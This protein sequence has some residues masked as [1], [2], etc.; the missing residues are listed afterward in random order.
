VR[1]VIFT[2]TAFGNKFALLLIIGKA[3][4]PKHR[5]IHSS[6]VPQRASKPFFR[7]Y[8]L[9]VSNGKQQKQQRQEQ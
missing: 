4:E 7:F 1:G 5:P 8:G 6:K 2:Q 3:F 9:I